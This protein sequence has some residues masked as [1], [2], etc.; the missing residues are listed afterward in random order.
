MGNAIDAPRQAK[1]DIGSVVMLEGW[2]SLLEYNS[3]LDA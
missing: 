3:R 2:I 1:G